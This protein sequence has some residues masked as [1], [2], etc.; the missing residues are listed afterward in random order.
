M[1]SKKKRKTN[2]SPS[3]LQNSTLSTQSAS[4]SFD[5]NDIYVGMSKVSETSYEV[6]VHEDCVVWSSGVYII[7]ARIVGLDTAVWSSTR[8]KC[9]ICSKNG[10]MISCLQRG[11]VEKAHISCAR[12]QG[13]DLNENE[14]KSTCEKHSILS[15]MSSW[16]SN[17]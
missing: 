14:F 5:I 17:C 6:W 16:N 8:Y 9:S 15:K 10:A 2:D 11:C 12:T 1:Q 4:P 13:W 7:G 3:I